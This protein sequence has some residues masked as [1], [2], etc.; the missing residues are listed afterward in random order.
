MSNLPDR[1]VLSGTIRDFKSYKQPNGSL[2]PGGHIDFENVIAID[3][4]IV[5]AAL[6]ANKKPVYAP[7]GKSTTTSGEANF[8]QWF[9]DVDGVNVS[10]PHELVLTLRNGVYTFDSRETPLNADKLGGFFP[11][12]GKGFGNEGRKHNYSFTYEINTS[13]TFQGTE[14]FTYTGDDD[15]WVFINNQLVIDLG[16]VHLAQKATINLKTGEATYFKLDG[17]TVEKV[18]RIPLNLQPGQVYDL[19]IFF[20]E[21]HTTQ[22]VF[23]ID[24]SLLLKPALPMATIEAT[25]P[26]ASKPTAAAGEFKISL[27]PPA[28]TDMVVYYAVTPASTAVTGVDY[29]ALTPSPIAFKQG[30]TSK[31]IPV[32]PGKTQNQDSSKTVVATIQPD[33]DGK[34]EAGT[35]AATVTITDI[36]IPK[37]TLQASKPN[38]SKVP[39]AVAGEFTITLD[40]APTTAIEIFYDL[41][42]AST[43]AAGV[44]FQPITG[45]SVSFNPGETTKTLPVNPLGSLNEDA[46]KTVVAALTKPA[47]LIATAYEVDT[48]PATVAITDVRI[49]IARIVADQPTANK[50]GP[51]LGPARN[52]SFTITLD[53]PLAAPLQVNYILLP[54]STAVANVDFQALTPV[55]LTFNPGEVSKAL[56]VIPLASL[57]QAATKTV[58]VALQPGNGYQPDLTPAEVTIT[59][60]VAPPPPPTIPVCSISAP[61]PKARRPGTG[62]P[63]VTGSFVLT[64]DQP[65]PQALT[66]TL[67]RGGSALPGVD[68]ADFPLTVTIPAGAVQSAPIIVNPLAIVVG[69]MRPDGLPVTL[70]ILPGAGFTV[71]TPAATVTIHLVT[72]PGIGP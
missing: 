35:T 14:S 72:T 71:G 53:K 10:I 34:Y 12:D 33:P 15:L 13:F 11:I 28:P 38:A 37:A 41:L 19:D 65:I 23:R 22:S 32:I 9:R 44:D 59:D 50:A 26:S 18:E 17:R 69:R 42:P 31:V 21:R 58:R 47:T 5:K 3:K 62:V 51:V 36:R 25:K 63:A 60:Q 8:N 64:L 27:S 67:A 57:N 39:T 55:P 24:T 30:E 68:F 7:I 6:D 16:G 56:P 2:N 20:A 66:I 48:T 4:G 40:Q 29:E 52:G 61:R 43:A 45:K 54:E 49:P 1:L 46:T 70:T